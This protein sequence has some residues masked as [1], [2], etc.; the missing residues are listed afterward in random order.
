MKT[1]LL[2]GV[3]ALA[4]APA[5]AQTVPGP[6]VRNES[7][8]GSRIDP[9]FKLWNRADAPGCALGV[10]QGGKAVFTGAWGSADL[11]HGVRNTP[12]TV[13]ESGSVAKQFTA[14]AL[15]TLVQDGKVA[16]ADDVRAYVPELPDYGAKITLEHLLNHTSGLRDWGEVAQIGGW[17][18][19]SR[20]Y[21]NADALQ[22]I[23]RQ[24]RLNYAPGE[25]YSYTNSGY[26][27]AAVV[28]ARVSGQSLAEFSRDRLFRPLGMVR[29]QWRD[30]FRRI[31]RDRAIAYRWTGRAWEQDM[32]FED[33]YGHGALLTTVADLLVWNEA[34]TQGRLGPLVTAELQRPSRLNDGR[35]IPYARGVF[36]DRHYSALEVA[37]GGAT[38]G[39]RTWLAR[40]PEQGLSVALL[41]NAADAN[42]GELG[43]RVVD[44]FLAPPM[45]AT[46][47][48]APPTPAEAV[49]GR[50]GVYLDD[51]TG[52]VLTLSAVPEGLRVHGGSTLMF[53]GPDQF[54][55]G[56]ETYAFGPDGTLER[57][58]QQ[59]ETQRFRKVAAWT[60]SESELAAVAGRYASAEADAVH[61][62]TVRDGR[63][64]LQA[65]DRPGAAQALTPLFPD[66][67]RIGGPDVLRIVRSP[68]GRIEALSFWGPR[69]RD[70]RSTRIAP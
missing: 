47:A 64:Y 65:D 44:Q 15:L 8:L 38:A 54:R 11:E 25:E 24:P 30:D 43:H 42:S 28:V 23:A 46:S 59:G 26:T 70:L 13:F 33:T 5:Q 61:V 48:A 60:P 58:T 32:P 45:P 55:S 29:T 37:H 69:V 35:V 40:Y 19:T 53:A 22:I 18:R 21:T 9:V 36:V 2:A 16:L 20:V 10:A 67:F 7:A 39:Y 6:A 57:R 49:S 27:L 63:L 31:V 66:A 52:L 1:L 17:P 14:A 34:L 56:G 68:D 4:A 62:L 51:R 41:C 12:Q 50:P 3:L